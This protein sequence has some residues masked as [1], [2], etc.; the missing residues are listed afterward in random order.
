MLSSGGNITAVSIG[1]G[2]VSVVVAE[3][4]GGRWHQCG[5]YEL[6]E[7]FDQ[8]GTAS[9]RRSLIKAV[10]NAGLGADSGGATSEVAVSI[11]DCFANVGV[12]SFSDFPD[13]ADDALSIVK[14]RVKKE[15]AL[16]ELPRLDY[17]V[18]EAGHPTKVLVVAIDEGVASAIEEALEEKGIGIGRM[19]LSSFHLANMLSDK[20][21]SHGNFSIAVVVDGTLTLM[22][23]SGGN[24]D[25]YRSKPARGGLEGLAS[26]LKMSFVSYGGGSRDH[27]LVAGK[28]EVMLLTCDY[29]AD[30]IGEVEGVSITLVDLAAIF[31]SSGVTSAS[32]SSDIL[33]LA[34][35]G[36]CL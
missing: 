19:G 33:R 20:A 7:D 10:E 11:S 32:G 14:L 17:Q 26:D 31:E 28:E 21:P 24:L 35:I 12:F 30:Q 23:F 2:Q 4:R 8:K 22:V 1:R 16:S 6:A 3:S 34:A 36:A 25:F 13:S 15:F 27:A 18:L 29:K 9:L 5:G